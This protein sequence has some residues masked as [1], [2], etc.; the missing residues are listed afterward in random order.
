M[1]VF[2]IKYDTYLSLS[3]LQLRLHNPRPNPMR[4][5][6][7]FFFLNLCGYKGLVFKIT[8]FTGYLF[9]MP[10]SLNEC[11]APLPVTLY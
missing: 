11:V 1:C 3:V 2:F 10:S 6:V 4:V 5:H 8:A 7:V 9:P